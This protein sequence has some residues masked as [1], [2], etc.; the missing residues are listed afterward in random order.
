MVPKDIEGH[1]QIERLPPDFASRNPGYQP[2]L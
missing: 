1:W 2:N